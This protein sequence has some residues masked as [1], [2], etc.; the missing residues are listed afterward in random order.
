MSNMERTKKDYE[1]MNF[2]LIEE[3]PLLT[4]RSIKVFILSMKNFVVI[5]NAFFR[6][7]STSISRIMEASSQQKFLHK[8]QIQSVNN[9]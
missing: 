2:Q 4:Q 6:L 9:M 3:L 7:V 1:A 8:Y 5:T